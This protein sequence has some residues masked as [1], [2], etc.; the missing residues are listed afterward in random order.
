MNAHVSKMNVNPFDVDALEMIDNAL[1]TVKECS[2]KLKAA[3][4]LHDTIIIYNDIINAIKPLTDKCGYNVEGRDVK[5]Y[6]M[7]LKEINA[8]YINAAKTAATALNA[9]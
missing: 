7:A 9:E 2:E 8:L 3:K 6:M 5:A 1:N 4:T